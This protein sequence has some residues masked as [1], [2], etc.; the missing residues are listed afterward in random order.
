M[1]CD[2]VVCLE[3]AAAWSK[4]RGRERESREACTELNREHCIQCSYRQAAVDSLAGGSEAMRCDAM[5]SDEQEANT[6]QLRG[7]K[8]EV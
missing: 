7:A 2:A 4:A 1:R 3:P 6:L 8:L 5:R